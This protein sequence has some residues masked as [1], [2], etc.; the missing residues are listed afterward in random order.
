[1][2]RLTEKDCL[3]KGV[4]GGSCGVLEGCDQCGHRHKINEKLAT[5]EDMGEPEE[6]V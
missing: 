1:M 2:S 6:L 4:C 5:Y 3:G